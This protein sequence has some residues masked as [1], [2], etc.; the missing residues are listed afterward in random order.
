[1][2]VSSVCLQRHLCYAGQFSKVSLFSVDPSKE[3]GVELDSTQGTITPDQFSKGSLST[4]SPSKEAGVELDSTQGTI[5]PDQFSKVST[6]TVSSSNRAYPA[7]GTHG[8][9]GVTTASPSQMLEFSL[10]KIT[11]SSL[12]SRVVSRIQTPGWSIK[13]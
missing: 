5:T 8:V 12:I 3:A 11:T 7:R 2:P 10:T 9:G 6:S 4:A 13:I 1:M